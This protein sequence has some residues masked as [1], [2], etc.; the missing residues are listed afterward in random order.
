MLI[1]T[2]LEGSGLFYAFDACFPRPF[3]LTSPP[4]CYLMERSAVL[5]CVACG[6]HNLSCRRVLTE[7]WTLSPRD[8]A[9]TGNEGNRGE[10][11]F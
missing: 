10:R 3:I 8:R 9:H 2:E 6:S 1:S 4:S 11:M 7:P 5:L